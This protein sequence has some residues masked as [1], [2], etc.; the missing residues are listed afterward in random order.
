MSQ[1]STNGSVDGLSAIT[2][3]SRYYIDQELFEREREEIFFKTWQFACHVSD[4]REPGDHRLVNV[5]GESII[6][7]RGEDGVVR[8]FYNVCQHRAHRLLSG[9]GNC[10]L[11]RCPY[12]AWSY[13]LNGKLVAAPGSELVPEFD[14]GAVQLRSVK[15]EEMC[16]L[17]FVNLDEDARS[18][19]EIYPG[20]EAEINAVKPGLAD[21]DLVYEDRV[22]HESNWK[23]SV[24]NFSE[25][26]HCPVVHKYLIAN[27]HSQ[28]DYQITISDGIVRH[29]CKRLTE[30]EVHGDL[31]I[32]FLWPNL[33]VE[34]FPMHKSISIR[35]FEVDGPRATTYAYLWYADR[36][37]PVAE[38]D[39]IAGT[40]RMIHETNGMED[41]ALVA[42]VQKGIESRGYDRGQLLITPQITPQSEHAVAFFQSTYLERMGLEN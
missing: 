10:K 2:M 33:A 6:V 29:D 25:C 15:L 11:I 34:L 14:H 3:P 28:D 40:G 17:L 26:Y 37:R 8:A 23:V 42:S 20:L 16:G 5:A 30:R 18:M 4:V 21:M 41:Q 38:K 12:H 1:L 36:D 35:H 7:I 31:K 22:S 24:E 27:Y 39:E 9:K 19:R 13:A 32:W